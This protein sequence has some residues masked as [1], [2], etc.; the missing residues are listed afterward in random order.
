MT[1]AIGNM[2]AVAV[3]IVCLSFVTI[4]VEASVILDSFVGATNS[5]IGSVVET[6]FR[7]VLYVDA[8]VSDSIG[9]EDDGSVIE[10]VAVVS[11]MTIW[12][13]LFFVCILDPIDDLGSGCT[14]VPAEMMMARYLTGIRGCV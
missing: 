5:S 12:A 3:L 7:S 8:N 2:A 4:P 14:C 1:A 9:A 6:G 11:G 10:S 13:S